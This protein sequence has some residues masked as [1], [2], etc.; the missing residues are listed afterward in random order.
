MKNTSKRKE[1]EKYYYFPA[2]LY[3]LV[4]AGNNQ[5]QLPTH[6]GGCPGI[7]VFISDLDTLEKYAQLYG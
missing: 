5:R 3:I 7:V 1:Q 4:E 2:S 6:S